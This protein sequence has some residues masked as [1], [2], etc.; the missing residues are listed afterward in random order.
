MSMGQTGS[1]RGTLH[2]E[3]PWEWSGVFEFEDKAGV[4]CCRKNLPT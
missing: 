3:T 2:I 1:E 4:N